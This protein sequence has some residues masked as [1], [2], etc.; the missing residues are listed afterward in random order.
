MSEKLSLATLAGGGAI[1]RFDDAL[2]QVVENIC[3]VN[4]D[5]KAK[6]KIT[7][8]VTFA[9]NEERDYGDV[10]IDCKPTLAPPRPVPTIAFFGK[11]GGEYI[12]VESNPKQGKLFEPDPED[13]SK[14]IP[15]RREE[16]EHA[17]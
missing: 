14:L 12:A 17:Q 6:R 16:E 10:S 8:T 1:E 9:P 11:R 2:V 15:M 4:T 5:P 7:L 13:P 3:D